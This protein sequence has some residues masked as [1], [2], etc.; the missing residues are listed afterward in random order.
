[1]YV[2]EEAGGR[3]ERDRGERKRES[4]SKSKRERE[5][6]RERESS[7]CSMKKV[8]GNHCTM[9]CLGVVSP[10]RAEMAGLPPL[11]VGPEQRSWGLI[12]L[13]VSNASTTKNS[14]YHKFIIIKSQQVQM[15]YK[16]EK[17]TKCTMKSQISSHIIP[18]KS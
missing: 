12:K 15:N 17:S 10:V 7:L 1:M 8:H 6:E 9:L 16:R 4:E 18:E 5:R 14:Q 13:A 3:E 11:G 2:D